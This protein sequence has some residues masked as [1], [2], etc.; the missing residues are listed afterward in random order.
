[1]SLKRKDSC[2]GKN[3]RDSRETPF[4]LTIKRELP[5]LRD[6]NLIRYPRKILLIAKIRTLSGR[7]N[8]MAILKM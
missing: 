8:F 7:E 1:M 2:N 5:K 4:N 6:N 3:W